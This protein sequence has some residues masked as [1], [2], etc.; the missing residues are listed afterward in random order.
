[1]AFLAVS[2]GIAASPN[3]TGIARS[4]CSVVYRTLRIKLIADLLAVLQNAGR[5]V[6][7]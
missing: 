3:K 1:M 7:E 6:T 2:G 5:E 4:L